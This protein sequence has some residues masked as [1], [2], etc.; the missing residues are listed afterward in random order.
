MQIKNYEVDEN[1]W[2][3]YVKFITENS[4]KDKT[5]EYTEKHH[6][7]PRALFPEI[8]N[9]KTNLVRLKAKDHLKAHYYL[10]KAFNGNRDM[11]TALNLMINRVWKDNLKSCLVEEVFEGLCIEYENFR[12]NLAKHISEMNTGK[13]LSEEAKKKLSEK[14][15][16]TVVVKDK[17][18][19]L[20]R[21]S[22][23]DERYK[24]GELVFYRVGYK[25]T[26]ETKQRMS[27]NGIKGLHM[28]NNGKK[29][30]YAETC[31][32][33]YVE[34]SLDSI[35]EKQSEKY[36]DM[37]YYYN[38]K[39]GESIR[40]KSTDEI[41]E[42]FVKKRIKKGNFV[43]WD[44]LNAECIKIYDLKDQKSKMIPAKDIDLE[45]SFPEITG[46][47]KEF[48]VVLYD[49]LYFY[50]I[51]DIEKYFLEKYNVLFPKK[52]RPSMKVLSETYNDAIIEHS[53]LV[54]QIKK[55][56]N[57]KFLNYEGHKFSDFFN[58]T[59]IKIKDIKLS[60][61]NKIYHSDEVREKVWQKSMMSIN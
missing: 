27:E 60:D 19:N 45:T 34:G 36:T 7:F 37:G 9:D 38:E 55:K 58:L 30:I 33:G 23:D 14:N 13:T 6:I 22:C 51:Q 57:E 50:R 24:S 44:K 18:G 46:N 4:I 52:I 28:Y 8:E 3:K 43:G 41:P 35:K 26:E 5:D 16:D 31:P 59:F 10:Y 2:N 49:G 53:F 42:G 39:T 48:K 61:T 47:A 21:V 25:H 20:M 40:L 1:Y 32:E 29:I 54:K 11:A 12:K 15:K 17:D 56:I